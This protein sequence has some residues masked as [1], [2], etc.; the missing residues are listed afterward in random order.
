MDQ[1]VQKIGE[2]DQIDEA[3]DGNPSLQK[4]VDVCGAPL[5][6]TVAGVLLILIELRHD[7]P[8]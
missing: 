6:P 3:I 1:E 8:K 4:L 7:K 2:R 5:F